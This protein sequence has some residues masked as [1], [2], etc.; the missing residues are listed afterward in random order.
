MYFAADSNCVCYLQQERVLSAPDRFTA[1]FD[2][3]FSTRTMILDQS[4]H[5]VQEWCDTAMGPMVMNLRDWVSDLIVSGALRLIE[6]R[7]VGNHRRKLQALGVPPG[8]MKWFALCRDGGAE[9]FFT[10]DIDF[11][12][13]RAKSASSERR[14]RI[15]RRG[16]APVKRFF[17]D[18][19]GTLVLDCEAVLD[20]D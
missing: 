20:V 10:E 4:G 8:D 1:A 2:R 9:V 17:R 3:L 15:K 16:P 11:F 19:I 18:E 6:T 14:T 7:P 12:D 13:P 5:C